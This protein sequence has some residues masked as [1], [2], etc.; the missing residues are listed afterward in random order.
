MKRTLLKSCGFMVTSLLLSGCARHHTHEFTHD[1]T[2]GVKPWTDLDFKN[3]PD[4]FQFVIVSDNSGGSRPGVFIDA[5]NK[6]NSIQPE[7]VLSVGDF[8]EGYTTNKMDLHHMWNHMEAEI[9]GFEM[10]FF[11]LPGNHDIS[12][13]EMQEVYEE[14]FGCRYY[15]FIYKNVLFLCLDMQDQQVQASLA[16]ERRSGMEPEQVDWCLNVLKEH[17]DVRW[18]FVLMHQPIW[19]YENNG[20][21]PNATG[22]GWDKVEEALLDRDFTVFAGHFHRYAKYVRNKKNYYILATTGGV[23]SLRGAGYGEFDHF[24][25]VTMTDGEPKIA[26][27]LLDGIVRDDVTTERVQ[28]FWRSLNSDPVADI[29]NRSITISATVTN[30]FNHHMHIEPRWEHTNSPGWH[31]DEDV[32][33]AHVNSGD[34]YSYSYTMVMDADA[35]YENRP[36]LYLQC[37]AGD[38]LNAEYEISVPFRNFVKAGKPHHKAAR[39]KQAPV[40]DGIISAEEWGSVNPLSGFNRLDQPVPSDTTTETKCGYDDDYFYMS[41]RCVQDP[42]ALTVNISDP[43]GEVWL[44]DSIEVFFDGDRDEHIWNFF[45]VTAN[46]VLKEFDIS[47]VESATARTEDAWTVEIKVPLEKIRTPKPEPGDSIGFN[48]RRN[49][50]VE[51]NVEKSEWGTTLIDFP[52]QVD[53]FGVIEME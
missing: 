44:D 31:V 33:S 22:T 23:S 27:L 9:S 49:R 34:T 52:H 6:I 45:I 17:P 36:M 21:A 11:Y 37:S 16:G 12:N 47:G 29:A 28:E 51:D 19:L 46:N 42:G 20:Q 48:V 41:I 1:V 13:V 5:V 26:N 7:F 10:P 24:V 14:R 35:N 50:V 25:W 38:E 39:V 43:E 15:S 30:H 8:I 40:I 2:T 3:N 18:T 53:L 4:E 32:K